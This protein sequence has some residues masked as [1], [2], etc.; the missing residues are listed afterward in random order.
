[1][2][3]GERFVCCANASAMGAKLEASRG[4]SSWSLERRKT[5]NGYWGMFS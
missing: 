2:E 1:M 4:V 5:S 3:G